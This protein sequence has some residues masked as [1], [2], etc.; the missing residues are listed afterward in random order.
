MLDYDRLYALGD[1]AALADSSSE[2]T[3]SI[4][5][6][7][8]CAFLFTSPRIENVVLIFHGAAEDGSDGV[9]AYLAEVQS[10]GQ[11]QFVGLREVLG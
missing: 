5:F 8:D 9:E 10:D 1:P 7:R 4:L 11:V 6:R 2:F 3:R